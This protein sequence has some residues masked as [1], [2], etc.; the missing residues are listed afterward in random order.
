MQHIPASSPAGV[1]CRGM[2]P[3]VS[4]SCGFGAGQ[5]LSVHVGVGE[6]K[7]LFRLQ[8]CASATSQPRDEDGVQVVLNAWNDLMF[9]LWNSFLK[10]T[11]F[12]KMPQVP[13]P[14]GCLLLLNPSA[15]RVICTK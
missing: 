6:N 2:A 7:S 3:P 9:S 1:L 4:L 15:T 10:I 14:V 5:E 13:E 12:P 11:S 8:S